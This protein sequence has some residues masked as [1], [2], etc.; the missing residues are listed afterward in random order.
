MAFENP[1][2][3]LLGALAQALTLLTREDGR[4]RWEAQVSHQAGKK[5][6]RGG[7]SW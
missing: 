1:R 4:G 7:A 6:Q 3:L 5:E 2:W